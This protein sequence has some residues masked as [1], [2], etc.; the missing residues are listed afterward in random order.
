VLDALGNP[1]DGKGNIESPLHYPAIAKAPDPLLRSRITKRISTG[2]RAID[3]LL[4]VGCGQRLGIFG[5]SGVGKSTLMGMIA[6]NNSADVNVVAL[7]GER[8]REINDFIENDLGSE[9]LVRSVLIVSPSDS[10]PIERLRGAYTAIAVAEYFRDQGKDVMLLF[11]SVTRFARAQREIGLAA[12]EPP[13]ASGYTPSVF[14]SIYRLLDRCGTSGK[15]RGTITGFY[16]I[17]ADEGDMDEPVSDTVLG[18]L[19]GC[20]VLS[21][22]LA[23]EDHYPAID[24]LRSSSRL[25]STV[26][27]PE[28]RKA[29]KALKQLM[30]CYTDTEN[31]INVGAYRG[32]SDPRIDATINKRD[33]IEKFLVQDVYEVSSMTDT[34][35][36]MEEITGIRLLKA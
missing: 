2:I 7:I 12:G 32:G 1:V 18:I 29:A 23:R 15:G 20:I 25:A 4:T 24:V 31:L 17:L 28:T 10:S 3:G 36:A 9:G 26:C 6:R 11:D 14:D 34:L 33:A 21:R 16:T 35:R 13:A 22:N 5:G 19:E 8:S 27:G 30:A